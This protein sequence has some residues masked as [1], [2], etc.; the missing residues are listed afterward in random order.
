[1]CPISIS[2]DHIPQLINYPLVEFTHIQKLL[3]SFV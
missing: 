3:K 2:S 1:M